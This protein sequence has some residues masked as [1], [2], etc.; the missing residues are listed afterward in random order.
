[1]YG[2]DTN[3]VIAV[4]TGRGAEVILRLEAELKA[5]SS[6][7]IPMMV[8]FELQYGAAKSAAQERNL[9]RLDDFMRGMAGIM[10]FEPEDAAEAGEIRA[11]LERQGTPIGAFDIL[12]A[13]QVRRRGITLVTA[14]TREFG[15]VP[16]LK[17]VDWGLDPHNRTA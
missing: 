6:I 17:V 2:L 14:N 9:A 8:W 4:L 15:R 1:M 7:H 12:I 5:R 16:G 11:H 10:A 13:A 3:A